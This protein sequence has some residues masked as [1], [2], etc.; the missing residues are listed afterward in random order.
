MGFAMVVR[1]GRRPFHS[2]GL[3]CCSVDI[4]RSVAR[5]PR[6]RARRPLPLPR[7]LRP[8]SAHVHHARLLGPRLSLP[9]RPPHASRITH[10]ALR[11]TY[12]A[13]RTTHYALI[14]PPRRQRRPCRPHPRPR[15]PR[16]PDRSPLPAPRPSSPPLYLRRARGLRPALAALAT[17]VHSS[18]AGCRAS[19]LD[20]LAHLARR[21]RCAPHFPRRLPPRPFLAALGSGCLLPRAGRPGDLEPRGSRLKARPARLQIP[22]PASTR[23]KA[24]T[25]QRSQEG[26]GR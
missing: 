22:R 12:N 16:P 10:H 13:P 9:H 4:E 8:G 7:P 6:H 17:R 5:T 3:C 19:L 14:P 21:P 24:S 2:S 1:V 18:G 26:P 20:S 11:I 23:K 15:P 25:P